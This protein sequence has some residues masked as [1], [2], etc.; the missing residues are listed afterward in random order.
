MG[1]PFSRRIDYVVPAEAIPARKS[2][3]KQN[4]TRT[5]L[6]QHKTADAN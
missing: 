2:I 6:R 5:K 4:L 1:L 3:R